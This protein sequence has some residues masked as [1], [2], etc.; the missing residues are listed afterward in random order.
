MRFQ[1]HIYST[2]ENYLSRYS[3]SGNLMD[4]K[5]D[6]P[7]N[8]HA[9][10]LLNFRKQKKLVVIPAACLSFLTLGSLS[11]CSAPDNYPVTLSTLTILLSLVPI[12]VLWRTLP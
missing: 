1:K 4:S 8:L 3:G 7:E 5:M 6:E 9:H 2:D 12:L 11:F 10:I